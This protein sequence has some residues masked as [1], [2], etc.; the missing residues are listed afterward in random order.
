VRRTDD[1]VP[2]EERAHRPEVHVAGMCVG[3]TAGGEVR[4]LIARRAPWREIAGGQ[5][6]GCGGQL[7]AGE[8]F[9]EGVAR[10]FRREL[11]IE[12]R[13]LSDLHRLYAIRRPGHPTIPGIRFLCE[14]ADAEAPTSARHTE[15][16]WVSGPEFRRIPAGEFAGDLKGE[17][18]GLLAAYTAG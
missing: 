4:L 2:R 8:T 15:V 6:E 17:V 5:Y 7:V 1:L 3:R 13:V 11:G 10:H 16:R 9:E 14:Q 12:V 18:L